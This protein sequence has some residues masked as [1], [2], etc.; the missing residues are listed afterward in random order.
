MIGELYSI[1]TTVSYKKWDRS[2]WNNLSLPLE[3]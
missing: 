3:A 1:E 2:M